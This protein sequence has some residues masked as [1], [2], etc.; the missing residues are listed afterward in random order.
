[1]QVNFNQSRKEYSKTFWENYTWPIEEEFSYVKCIV[2]MFV[3]LFFV[4]KSLFYWGPYEELYF[5]LFN[6]IIFCNEQ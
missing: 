3:F 2:S 5:L 1:M 4:Q 6:W